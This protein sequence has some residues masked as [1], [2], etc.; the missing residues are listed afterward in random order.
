MNLTHLKRRAKRG[1][2]TAAVAMAL[3]LAADPASALPKRQP[4]SEE[5]AGWPAPVKGHVAVKPGEHPRLLFRKA[6]LPALRE[7]AKTPEGQAAI[8]RLR[9]QLNGSDGESMPRI[10]GPAKG[11]DSEGG[12]A[13]VYSFSHMAGFGLLYQLTGE[14]KYADLG[15][16]CMEKAFE[17]TSNFDSRYGFKNPNGALRAGPSV[18]WTA[19]GYDLCYDGWDEEYRLKVAKAIAEYSPAKSKPNEQD[20]D[21]P[22]LARGQR[23]HPGSNHWGMI[24]GG[25][26]MALLA[27]QGDPGVDMAQIK[28]LLEQSEQCMKINL[29]QGFGDGGFFVEG[30]GTGSMSSH[31]IFLSALQAWRIVEGKDFYTPKP[32]A[33]WTSLKW[34]FLTALG[35]DPN[36]LRA[37]FPERGDYP[38]NI[39]SRGGLSGAN[40][41]GIGFGVATEAQ[42]A[43]LLWYYNHAG[44][45]DADAKGGFG[46]DAPSPYPHHSILSF[47]NWPVGMA[48]KNPQGI[49]PNA[50]RDGICKFYAWRNRW[51]DAD[52][53]ILSILT[54]ATKGNM[55][56]KAE[57][58]LTIQTGGKKSKWGTIGSG[59]TGDWA[60][61]ADGSTVL[62]T[63]DGSCLA[64]DFSKASGADAMLV[65]TGPGAPGG[66]TVEAGGV[67]FSF[68]FPAKGASP[69]PE[70]AGD[71][72]TVGGQTVSFDGKKIVLAK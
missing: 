28:P 43:A 24:V 56:S 8:K 62:T 26:A 13:G 71:K 11:G 53:V 4:T 35:G 47:V 16:Q 15:K 12:A 64:V 68:L 21:L 61:K 3:F 48:E 32:N 41:F 14:K 42:K 1:M 5:L 72:V 22:G 63:G 17:G 37:S 40:Y 39:W 69:K 65:M 51:Q 45:K 29:T 20:L 59:F 55:G 49:I 30:D 60:P 67:K 25:G 33:Q 31:I 57:N 2:A 19:L 36:N 38:H 54:H 23:Q 9:Q 46:L 70:A 7:K 18:G 6:D 58:T 10:G 34:P 50:Y 27:I 52:D 44:L 66:A